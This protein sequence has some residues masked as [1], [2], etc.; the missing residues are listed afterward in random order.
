M[1]GN[2][3]EEITEGVKDGGIHLKKK[4]GNGRFDL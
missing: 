3:I 2:T 4:N 1:V